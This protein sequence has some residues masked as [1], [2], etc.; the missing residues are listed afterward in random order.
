MHTIIAAILSQSST[1]KHGLHGE[2]REKHG[3]YTHEKPTPPVKTLHPERK[4]AIYHG[5]EPVIVGAFDNPSQLLL[6]YVE[7][8][9][10]AQ[11][12]TSHY[13]LGFCGVRC[14]QGCVLPRSISDR[15]EPLLRSSCFQRTR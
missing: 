15:V 12:V 3:L 11:P 7:G 4:S 10:K 2:S 13:R 8:K 14:S 1:K 5:L 9:L 6:A